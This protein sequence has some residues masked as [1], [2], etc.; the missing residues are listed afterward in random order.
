ME[1]ESSAT[2]GTFISPIRA[3]MAMK[4]KTSEKN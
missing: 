3:I 1:I 2:R 4:R